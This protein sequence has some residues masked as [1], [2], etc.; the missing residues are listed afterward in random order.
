MKPKELVVAE[1]ES[2]VNYREHDIEPLL[3]GIKE[4]GQTISKH[5]NGPVGSKWIGSVDTITGAVW[6][7]ECGAAIGT[8]EFAAYAKKKLM[9][10]DYNK[11]RA[12]LTG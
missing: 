5:H 3:N 6:A 9:D 11:F 1:G 7:K 4:R 8:K 12:D 10:P 2:I